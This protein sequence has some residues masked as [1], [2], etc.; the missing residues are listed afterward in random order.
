MQRNFLRSDA[1]PNELINRIEND[2]PSKANRLES[3]SDSP[4]ISLSQQTSMNLQSWADELGKG[5][6]KITNWSMAINST[7]QSPV[8]STPTYSKVNSTQAQTRS[9]HTKSTTV[10]EETS[11]VEVLPTIGTVSISLIN[12]FLEISFLNYI[13]QLLRAILL[14]NKSLKIISYFKSVSVYFKDIFEYLICIC[15]SIFEKMFHFLIFYSI[16]ISILI[17]IYLSGDLMNSEKKDEFFDRY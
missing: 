11:F 12:Y 2:S 4:D 7:T 13:G 16:L 10:Q 1:A 15:F 8:I 9:I 14:V 3:I 5:L 17:F 6:G